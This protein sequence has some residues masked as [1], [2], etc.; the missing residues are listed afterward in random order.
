MGDHAPEARAARGLHRGDPQRRRR[1]SPASPTRAPSRPSTRWHEAGHF[2]HI[3]SHRPRPATTPPTRWLE[4]IG[5]RFDELYCSYD[6]VIAL[7]RD[8]DRRADRRQPRQPPARAGAPGSPP[9][10]SCTPGTRTSARSED[11]IAAAT[12]PSWPPSSSRSSPAA[13]GGPPD[14]RPNHAARGARRRLETDEL[15]LTPSGPPPGGP[16]S[17]DL[18]NLLPGVEPERQVDDW[19]RSERIE[20]ADGPHADRVLLPAVVP[21]RGRG[22]RERPDDGRRAAGLQPR[23]R[24]AARRGDDRQGDQGGAP[25]PAAA[26]HDRRALLQGLP[27][28]Q[29]AGAEDR[30]RPRASGQRAPAALRRAP[31]RARLPR[32][33]QGHREA[34]QGPLPAAALRPRRLRRGRDAGASPDRPD[35]GRR[36]RGGAADLRP[37]AAAAEAHRAHLL[38]DHADVPAARPAG[39][40]RLPARQVQDPLPGAGAHRRHGRRA[41]GGQGAGP[42][43]A[44][45]IR[46]TIQEELFDM[47]GERRS[48]WFG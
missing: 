32:G 16:S 34:L 6:K 28:L 10:R 7:R 42:E 39:T 31:A 41:V 18:R 40:A 27:G 15:A 12:G 4:Q 14:G 5:L 37:L 26:L 25:P 35:R 48:V 21:L 29:H 43:V 13:E 9:R 19:G 46:A 38:P 45:D 24:A 22:H 2:I 17:S 44:Q 11:V 1:S 8:R 23:R 47:V 33:P 20:G 36:R 3:T 30:R